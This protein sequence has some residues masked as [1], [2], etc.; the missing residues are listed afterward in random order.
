MLA[1]QSFGE[2]VVHTPAR[3]VALALPCTFSTFDYRDAVRAAA[4]SSGDRLRSRP[5]RS[6]PTGDTVQTDRGEMPRR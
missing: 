2:I 4:A 1:A 5:R 6:G 3:D